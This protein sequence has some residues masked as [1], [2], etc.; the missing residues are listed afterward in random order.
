MAGS[1]HKICKTSLFLVG[2]NHWAFN[3]RPNLSGKV[4]RLKSRLQNSKKGKGK[5]EKKKAITTE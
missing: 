5:K 4:E 2:S 3:F 1:G